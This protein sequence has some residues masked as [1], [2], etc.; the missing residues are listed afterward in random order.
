MID[1]DLDMLNDTHSP[2]PRRSQDSTTN[3][4]GEQL[5]EFCNMFDCAILNG[6]CD[7]G[8]DDS[9]TYIARSGSSV[10]DYYLMSCDLYYS[11]C[12]D[13]LVVQNLTESDHLPVVLTSSIKHDCTGGN[14]NETGNNRKKGVEKMLWDKEK[15]EDFK[16]EMKSRDTQMKLETA[17]A[18]IENDIDKALS[19]FIDCI[20]SA[21]RCMVKNII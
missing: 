19:T 20:Q 10:V 11:V 21:S 12:I 15:E 6:L 4:F 3:S 16:K 8:F 7:P 13:S 5:L 14:T 9:Y 2:L 17:T 18:D 1:D